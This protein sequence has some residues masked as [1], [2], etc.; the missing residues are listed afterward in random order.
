M[1]AANGVVFGCNLDGMRGT[2]FA[3]D[4]KSG[5]IL[6]SYDSNPNPFGYGARN[7]GASIAHGTVYWGTGSS[8][9]TGPHLVYAFGL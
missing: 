1:S 2:M 5:N 4:A 3:L 9:G 8:Y 6:W 7:T